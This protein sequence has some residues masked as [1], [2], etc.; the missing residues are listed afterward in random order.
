M[1]TINELLPIIIGG[2]FILL[3]SRLIYIVIDFMR[4][5]D[6]KPRMR[7]IR[8]K[9]STGT[10]SDNDPWYIYGIILGVALQIIILFTQQGA[11]T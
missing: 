4:I 8:A 3:T 5:M 11:P 7:D 9:Y 6:G 2:L 10:K 1:Q